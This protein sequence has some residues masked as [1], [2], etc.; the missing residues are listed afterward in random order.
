VFL[1]GKDH[2][3]PFHDV[4][5]LDGILAAGTLRAHRTAGCVVDVAD[6]MT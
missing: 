3:L 2:D 4:A 1:E 5:N 6:D